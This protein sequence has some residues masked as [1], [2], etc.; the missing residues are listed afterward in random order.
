MSRLVN[1]WR[2]WKSAVSEAIPPILYLPGLRWSWSQDISLND[3]SQLTSKASLDTIRKAV[4]KR[5]VNIQLSPD[6]FLIRDVQIPK[7]GQSETDSILKL[8]LQKASP[9]PISDFTWRNQLKR[10]EGET[11]HFKQYVIKSKTLAEISEL[12]TVAGFQLRTV[13]V[14]TNGGILPLID[15][16]SVTDRPV[17]R[18]MAILFLVVLGL[19][20]INCWQLFDSYARTN[21]DIALLKEQVIV[22]RDRTVAKIEEN[23]QAM[24]TGSEQQQVYLTLL[25]NRA[26]AKQLAEISNSFP[27]DAWISEFE[28]NDSKAILGGFLGS[29][30]SDVLAALNRQETIAKAVLQGALS[31]G[32]GS[33]QRRF[34]ISVSFTESFQ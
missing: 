1:L 33:S 15:S 26:R 25:S 16:R 28:V 24:Q 34:R 32:S 4:K 18:W 14:E 2:I 19:A 5:P 23:K 3:I 6:F 30:I 9:V 17:R 22:L 29:D 10:A 20:S 31:S 13:S 21:K 11:L 8:S 12:S 27:L 7:S